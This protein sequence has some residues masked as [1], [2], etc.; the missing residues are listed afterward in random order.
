MV[1][2]LFW[3]KTWK[4]QCLGEKAKKKGGGVSVQVQN[5]F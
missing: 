3:E 4:A 1:R 5:W 2:P